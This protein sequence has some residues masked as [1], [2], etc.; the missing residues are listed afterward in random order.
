MLINEKQ[1]ILVPIDF[2]PQSLIG[3]KQ[4]YNL[5]KF[6]KSKLVLLYVMHKGGEKR[7]E[8]FESLAQ[9]TKEESGLDV[10]TVTLEGEPFA[11]ISKKANE[12]KA[13]LVIMGIDSNVQFKNFLGMNPLTKFIFACPC[14][15]ITIRGTENRE[16]CKNIILPFDLTPESREKVSFAV[17]L[18]R[19]YGSDIRIV[20]VFPP[21]DDKYENK[22]LPYLQQ[23]KKFIKNEGIHCTNKSIP[24]NTAAQAIVDYAISH[25]GDLLIQMNQKDMSFKEYIN[26]TV[27]Q[28]I[29]DICRIPV[30]T[31]NPMKRESMSHFGSGM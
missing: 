19:Y 6:T 9:K 23:V 2:L 20:S 10:E 7:V 3:L 18:A 4:S 1:S 15:V 8:E 27:G 16:G 31:I 25:E 12:I 21:D 17:Q 22:L 5:A 29:L 26:G 30:M 13:S 28:K 14:P 11:T 24:S